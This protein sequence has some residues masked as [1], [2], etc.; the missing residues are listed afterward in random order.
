MRLLLRHA[1]PHA[2]LPVTT[3]IALSFGSLF[4]GALVVETMFA[5]LGMGKLIYDSILGNDYNIALV[6]LMLATLM[7]LIE[8]SRGGPRLCLARPAHQLRRNT[9]LNVRPRLRISG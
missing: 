6:G 8:Q 7:T 2:M 3:M 1:L 4:S 5:Y 9:S